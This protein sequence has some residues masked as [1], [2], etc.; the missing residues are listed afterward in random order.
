MLNNSFE[1]PSICLA[2]FLTFGMQAHIPRVPT[3]FGITT[4]PI[5]F[6]ECGLAT[7]AYGP[8]LP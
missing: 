2:A 6:V 5:A 7:F 8:C 3:L 1:N 4:L